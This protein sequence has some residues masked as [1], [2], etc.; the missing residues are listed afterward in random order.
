MDGHTPGNSHFDLRSS[1][2]S[3]APAYPRLLP[4]VVPR[5]QEG[6][7]FARRC[8]SPMRDASGRSAHP[9]EVLPGG[10]IVLRVTEGR[11]GPGEETR[12][13][14]QDFSAITIR[15]RVRE[16]VVRTVR[17]PPTS[18][19]SPISRLDRTEVRGLSAI[20][21]NE[22]QPSLA[23]AVANSSPQSQGGSGGKFPTEGQE[24]ATLR[25]PPV[26]CL[27]KGGI[28]RKPYPKHNLRL[29]P[30]YCP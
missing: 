22:L 26:S 13:E 8:P 7:L 10:S 2:G 29:I 11:R 1:H 19:V 4:A 5:L 18:G 14:S 9:E 15:E 12:A 6:R 20:P 25:T 30:R 3:K 21:S 24:M 27:R 23:K 28:N 17:S 16:N